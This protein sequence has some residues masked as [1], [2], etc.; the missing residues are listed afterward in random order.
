MEYFHIIIIV[1]QY[2]YASQYVITHVNMS[3]W[4]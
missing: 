2:D 1:P 4:H 3:D